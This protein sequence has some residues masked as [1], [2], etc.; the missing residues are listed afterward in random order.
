MPELLRGP[1]HYVGVAASVTERIFHFLKARAE[2]QGGTLSAGDL[3]SL[4]QQFLASLPKAASYFEG[5][6]RQ[7]NEAS[8]AEHVSRENILAK[9]VFACTH[10]AARTAFPQVER[11]GAN[12]LNQ[13]CDGIANYIRQHVC[14]D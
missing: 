9:L 6:D 14:T 11:I 3:V 13:L 1:H 4:R 7:Y 10:K 12:W 2:A 8:A 5:V